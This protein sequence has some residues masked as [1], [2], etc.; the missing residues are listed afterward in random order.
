MRRFS[1]GDVVKG[2]FPDGEWYLATVEEEH[3]DGTYTVTWFDGDTAN[4]TKRWDELKPM[5][6]DRASQQFEEDTSPQLEEEAEKSA[7]LEPERPPR[8]AQAE[9]A[10]PGHAPN[11]EPENEEELSQAQDPDKEA[12]CLHSAEADS[13]EVDP[14]EKKQATPG[15]EA[16]DEIQT[17]EEEPEVPPST[18]KEPRDEEPCQVLPADQG[19]ALPQKEAAEWRPQAAEVRLRAEAEEEAIWWEEARREAALWERAEQKC[20]AEE[21]RARQL[22]EE[23]AKWQQEASR[24]ERMWR[25]AMRQDPAGAMPP[26]ARDASK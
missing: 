4:R 22:A 3:G 24:E 6:F 2:C 18:E 17:A 26:E 20:S 1:V 7:P 10:S 9:P 12:A 13:G 8:D 19:D 23:L 16:C 21:E 5:R 15:T 25:E 11:W 14:C